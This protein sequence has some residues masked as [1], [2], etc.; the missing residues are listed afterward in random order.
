MTVGLV[1]AYPVDQVETFTREDYDPLI[2][3][4]S[5]PPV[6]QRIR[7][8]RAGFGDGRRRLSQGKI[9]GPKAPNTLSAP[10]RFVRREFGG[11]SWRRL[12]ETVLRRTLG[13][14]RGQTVLIETGS[15]T[16]SAAEVLTVEAR[17]LGIRPLLMHVPEWS[18]FEAQTVAAPE[19]ANALSPA[20]VAA[21]KASSGYILLPPSVETIRR[22]NQLPRSHQATIRVR[23]WAWNR[24]L[25]EN[26]IPSVNL[27][28]ASATRAD[29]AIFGVDF[30][31]WQREIVAASLVAPRSIR[32]RA[33]PLLR[34]LRSGREL[35]I[36]HRNGTHLALRLLGVEPMLD[37]GEIRSSMADRG[38][39]W[40]T[41][42]SGYLVVPL[43][44]RAA[45]GRLRSNVPFHYRGD[46]IDG[47]DWT[48][49][50]G[51]LR[52]IDARNGRKRY[53]ESYRSA[54]RERNRPGAIHIGLNP[55]MHDLPGL[56]D[57]ELGVIAVV[58][59]YNDDIGGR[60]HGTYRQYA[61]I[62][63]GTLAVDGKDIVRSGRLV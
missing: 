55:E 9:D 51:R 20:E 8:L 2:H 38:P 3:G 62:R 49:R 37:A 5:P 15:E 34:A 17:R 59:G 19:D 24:L 26:S 22:R 1:I 35:T 46:V 10:G 28:A 18:F 32:S 4:A 39:L 44:E 13:L 36:T 11:K 12:A 56:E 23:R 31:R 25:I 57:Q 33:K 60:T 53:L 7:R 16:L 54:G 27:L 50:G 61:D 47:I 40:T 52:K 21:L 43:D 42:P 63:G 58:I 48:F 41:V 6:I 30:G 14:R 29:A 45:E